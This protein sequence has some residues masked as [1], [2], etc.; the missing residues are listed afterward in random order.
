M[1]KI[2]QFTAEENLNRVLMDKKTRYLVVE[3]ASDMPIYSEVVD[4]LIE[5]HGLKHRPIT[6]FGGGKPNILKW[7]DKEDP[8]NARVILDL[9][10][11][12]PDEELA[13]DCVYPLNKYSIEN[14]FFDESVIIPL[15]SHL[16]RRNPDDVS[17]AISI[18]ELREHWSVELDELL[19]VLFY[20]QKV[21]DG[22]KERWTSVYL[23]GDHGDWKIASGRVQALKEQLLADMGID[24]STCKKEFDSA[25]K[26]GWCPCINFPGKILMESFHRYLK[27]LCNQERRRSYSLISNTGSLVAHLASRLIRSRDL[28][29]ILIQALS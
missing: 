3:G 12:D 19:P 15:I 27:E 14:Y 16:L 1:G 22:D 10:F 5:K 13:R 17:A 20:Y 4:L 28:E 21:F 24:F 9:D 23:T 6:V 25:F 2:P 7:L 29:P 18:K 11:D 8:S 26:S